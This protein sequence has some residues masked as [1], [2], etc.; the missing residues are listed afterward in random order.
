MRPS[1]A[2]VANKELEQLR[3]T[4]ASQRTASDYVRRAAAASYCE[5]CAEPIPA[6]AAVA[7]ARAPDARPQLRSVLRGVHPDLPVDSIVAFL[8]P[9]RAPRGATWVHAA[10]AA[11]QDP[12][13]CP[14][15]AAH[16]CAFGERC[17]FAHR[18]SPGAPQGYRASS[19]AGVT[20]C[21]GEHLGK[22]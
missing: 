2:V 21:V 9:W 15:F 20:L 18:G 6:G 3:A 12:P 16:G 11:G 7:F 13:A 4:P 8:R 14:H 10:C 17:L 1:L 22:S 19:L 5:A